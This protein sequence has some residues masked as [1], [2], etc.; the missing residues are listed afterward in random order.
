MKKK[1]VLKI[2]VVHIYNWKAKE[3]NRKYYISMV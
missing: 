2:I 1:L 3:T